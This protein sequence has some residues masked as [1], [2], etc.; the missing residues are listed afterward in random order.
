MRAF[1]LSWRWLADYSYVANWLLFATLCFFHLRE[2]GPSRLKAKAATLAA[3]A[4]V[5]DRDAV[6]RAGRKCRSRFGQQSYVRYLKP[7]ALRLAPAQSEDAFFA[8]AA[9]IKAALDSARKEP[10][11][12]GGI[13][14]ALDE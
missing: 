9:R 4:A 11:P 5:G 7:P 10:P 3:L 8:D 13:F 12:G 2:I 14:P 1:S 6:G